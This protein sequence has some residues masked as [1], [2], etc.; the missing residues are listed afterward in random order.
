MVQFK[1][2]DLGV[3]SK[4]CTSL[5]PEV[6][7]PKKYKPIKFKDMEIS[8]IEKLVEKVVM[9]GYFMPSIIDKLLLQH[10]NNR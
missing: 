2:Y 7:A 10:Y 4:T 1:N 9:G 6:F 5:K 3:L 8:D